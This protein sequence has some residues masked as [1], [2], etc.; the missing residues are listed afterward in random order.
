[1]ERH[2]RN[3][4][5]FSALAVLTAGCGT[6][7]SETYS[8]D[9]MLE[10]GN[11]PPPPAGLAKARAAVLEFQDKT[12]HEGRQQKPIG[13]QA[14]EELETL[15]MRSGRFSLVERQQMSNLLREQRLEG[16]VDPA[17]LAKPGRIRG[18]D[19]V[20]LGTITNFR[21]KVIKTKTAGGI[22][23]MVIPRLAPIDIDTSKTVVETQ[24][25]VDI[26]LVNTNTGEIVAKDFGEVKRED[27]ASAWGLR[28]LGIGGNAKNELII[29]TESQGKILRWALDE[30][31]KKMLPAI[32][33]KFSRPQPSYCGVCK[34]ELPP[35]TKF[36]SKCGASVAKPKCKCGAELEYGARFCTNCGAKVEGAPPLPDRPAPAP[37]PQSAPPPP[38]A[39][40]YMPEHLVLARFQ[41]S[42]MLFPAI[43]DK[44]GDGGGPSVFVDVRTNMKIEGKEFFKTRPA[45]EAD[46]KPGAQVFVV[47]LMA[48]QA[49]GGYDEAGLAARAWG[50]MTVFWEES[51]MSEVVDAGKGLFKA[52]VAMQ[53]RTV[54]V[55]NAR[56][57]VQ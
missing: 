1:M 29:D 56:V 24:V 34:V 14:G 31:F 8:R 13:A 51:R 52:A 17:E 36:C 4:A 55:S 20:F 21:V 38:P 15:V 30:S 45:S 33:E 46:L 9:P 22:F 18:V 48:A 10:I 40:D 3:I 44:K 47:N 41:D 27:V 42:P 35:G 43:L 16:I 6:T 53:Q 28:V 25:G 49:E 5:L 57:A 19:Y 11:Y 32:D 37:G 39:R 2:M 12:E 54:H 7:T 50:K 23:D 26:K